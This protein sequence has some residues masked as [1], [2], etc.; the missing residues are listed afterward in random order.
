MKMTTQNIISSLTKIGIIIAIVILG[1]SAINNNNDKYF[2]IAKN[3]EIFTNVYKELNTHYVD[4]LE[5]NQLIRTGIDAMMNSLDPYTV[6]YSESQVESYRISVDGKYN[7]LGATSQNIDDLVTIV[8]IYKDGPAEEAGL[9]VGDQITRVNG[10]STQG[11]TYDEVVQFIRG[12]PGTALQISV[13]RPIENKVY[14]IQI[15]RSEVDIPNVPYF[16]MVSEDVGYVHLTTFTQDAANNIAKALRS[17]RDK[18]EL[19]GVILDLRGNGGGLLAEAIDILG[20]FL[21]QGTPVVSTRGK[22]KDRDQNYSTRRLPVDMDLPLVV[23]I[24]KNSA[25]ASEI[26]S[27]SIQDMDRGV[28]MGQRSYGKGLVQNHKEVGYNS[29]IKVTTSKYYIPSGRCIQ[30][31]AY[32]NGEPKDIPDS[33]REV[34]YSRNKRPVLDGGGVTPDIKLEKESMPDIINALHEGHWIFKYANEYVNQK[35]NVTE[36]DSFDF[37]DYDSFKSFLVKNKFSFKTEEEK[38]LDQ[39]K[40]KLED[41]LAAPLQ[42]HVDGIAQIIG[43]SKADDLIEY[44]AL[45]EDNIEA[46]LAKRYFLQEGKTRQMLKN[47][48]EVVKAI[49]LLLDTTR[50][51]NIL[52]I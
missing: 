19:K 32:E 43:S 28:V 39:L 14:D 36:F 29:R 17:L 47:D 37:S 10:Q 50:Y 35:P 18:N 52:H 1:S 26:V 4:D 27:G 23:L 13:N 41:D 42:Q 7:G 8:E 21:P 5:P 11:K 31:V 24:D 20:L 9:K 46:E 22:V 51:N 2:E 3:L 15:T 44:Q 30:A 49:E 33:Q 25:S 38:A 48:T 6:F 45:I 12:F 16:G 34:F 40:E